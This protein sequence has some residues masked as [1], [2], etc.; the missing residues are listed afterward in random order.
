MRFLRLIGLSML[1]LVLA[2]QPAL[3]FDTS[4]DDKLLMMVNM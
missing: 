1:M 3:A 4:K 2:V